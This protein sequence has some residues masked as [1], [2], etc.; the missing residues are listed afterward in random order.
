VLLFVRKII[1]KRSNQP[2]GW[3]N[4]TTRSGPRG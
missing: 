3:I 4:E 2:L 1:A